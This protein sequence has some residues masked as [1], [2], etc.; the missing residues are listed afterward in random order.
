MNNELES[1]LQ[2]GKARGQGKI[3]DQSGWILENGFIE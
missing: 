2:G 3:Y 1:R